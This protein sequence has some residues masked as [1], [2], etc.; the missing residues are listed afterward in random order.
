MQF[1]S[2]TVPAVTWPYAEDGIYFFT[3]GGSANK[4]RV[5]PFTGRIL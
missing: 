4:H 3:F 2:N 1:V 5:L